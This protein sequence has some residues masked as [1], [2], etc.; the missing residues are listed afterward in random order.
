MDEIR[1]DNLKIRANHGVLDFEKA[2]GQDFYVNAVLYT[3]TREAGLGDNLD[4]STDYSKVCETIRSTMTDH[5]YDLIEAVAEH[6]AMDI[7]RGYPLIRAVDVEIRKPQAPVPMEFESISVKIHRGWSTVYLSYGSNM[8]DSHKLIDEAMEK[9]MGDA[10]IRFI[11]ESERI[12]TKPYGGVEQDDFVNGACKIETLY[13]PEELL[14]LLHKIEAEAGR[15]RDVRWGPRTLDLDIVLFEK[16]VYESEDL[17]I[18]HVDMENREFVL[19]PMC[20]LAPNMRHPVL[21]L[22]MEQLLK[23]LQSGE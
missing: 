8:G 15:V 22:T 9:L 11:K 12:V 4:K 13:N 10:S 14:D 23:K 19:K 3:S 20:E 5:T 1:I 21:G 7:L 2:N 6:V 18:P 16:K 17:I